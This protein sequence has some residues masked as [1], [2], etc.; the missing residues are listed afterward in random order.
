MTCTPLASGA[1]RASRART[2]SYRWMSSTIFPASAGETAARWSGRVKKKPLSQRGHACSCGV[3]GPRDLYSAFLALCMAGDTFNADHAKAVWSSVDTRLQAAL[4][5]AQSVNGGH[6]PSSFGRKR[7]QNRSPA[8]LGQ[9]TCETPEG[10][11]GQCTGWGE[12]AGA[13]ST[14][15]IPH[16]LV[17]GVVRDVKRGTM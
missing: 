13:R 16:L 17:W 5:T 4:S 7:S 12:P 10:V 6:A 1:D 3:V 2:R 8:M 11:P 15:R 14:A 9:E